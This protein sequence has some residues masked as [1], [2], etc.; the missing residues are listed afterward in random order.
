MSRSGKASNY[1]FFTVSM[2]LALAAGLVFY[3]VLFSKPLI[4][5]GIIV[6]KIFVPSRYVVGPNVLNYRRYK[7][8][9]HV[10]TAQDDHQWI[11]FVKMEDDQI[12]K[13][14]CHT[15][16]YEKKQVGDILHFKEYVGEL[17]HIDYFSHYEEDEKLENKTD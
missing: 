17:M 3:D 2:A 15:D 7:T 9:D 6:D 4:L 5:S 16:H 11:A 12:L 10:V 13:V 1:I 14:N 8:Y